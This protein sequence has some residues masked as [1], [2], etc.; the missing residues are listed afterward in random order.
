MQGMERLG[1][2]MLPMKPPG[3]KRARLQVLG[4][5]RHGAFPRSRCAQFLGRMFNLGVE[6]RDDLNGVLVR[7]LLGSADQGLDPQKIH[8]IKG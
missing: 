7:P 1:T 4:R 5:K 3:G 8:R 2:S 6:S